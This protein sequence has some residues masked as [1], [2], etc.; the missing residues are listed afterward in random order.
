[1]YLIK[2]SNSMEL[3]PNSKVLTQSRS[4]QNHLME[5]SKDFVCKKNIILHVLEYQTQCMELLFRLQLVYMVFI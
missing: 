1:M 5:P 4:K 2:I 3:Y